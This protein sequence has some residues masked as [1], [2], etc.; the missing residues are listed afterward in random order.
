MATYLLKELTSPSYKG[1]LDLG[2]DL[3]IKQKLNIK[4]LLTLSDF[5]KVYSQTI[6]TMAQIYRYIVF[7]KTTEIIYPSANCQD[8][9]YIKL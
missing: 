9:Y 2:K 5:L 1:E 6:Y 7:V 3:E 8:I 4:L